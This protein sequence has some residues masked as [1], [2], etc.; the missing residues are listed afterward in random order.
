MKPIFSWFGSKRKIAPQVWQRFGKL[1]NFVEPFA[2]SLSVL[3]ANP[4]ISKIETVNDQNCWLSNF[5][6][7]IQNDWEGVKKHADFPVNEAD[8]HARH[9]FLM[10]SEKEFRQKMEND[11]DFFDLKAAGWWIWGHSASVGSNWLQ[12]K[13]EKA[14]PIL[15]S[16]GGGIHGLT[17]DMDEQFSKFA[18]RVKK[19]RVACGNWKRVVSPAVLWKNKGLTNGEMTG[20]F[21]DPPYQQEMREKK[22]YQ[23]DQDVFSDV[24]SWALENGENEKMRIAVCGYDP[25]QEIFPSSWEKL[26]WSADGGMAGLSKG[27]KTRGKEN[28]K[29]EVIWF[30]PHCLKVENET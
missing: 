13:G 22:I 12:K 11:P 7:A 26:S 23:H 10:S 1:A 9:R 14:L 25:D 18:S 3:L 24:V 27:T 16:A 2:G 30:S 20:V 21:L 28:S 6:R 4:E 17:F 19:V 5:F 8:L 29:K 15:S